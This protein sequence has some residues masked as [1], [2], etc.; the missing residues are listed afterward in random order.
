MRHFKTN[1][2][3]VIASLMVGLFLLLGAMAACPGLHELLH[4]DANTPGHECA[5]TMF[6]HGHVDASVVEVAASLPAT[7][8]EL[9]LLF[10]VS[11][12]DAHVESLPRDR[13]P[14]VFVFAS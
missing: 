7:P 9:Q 1:G 10:P 4:Q 12:C 8:I 6:V 3:A 11:A 5:V 2:Q 13:G 14:P